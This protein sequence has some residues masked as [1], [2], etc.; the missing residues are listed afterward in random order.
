MVSFPCGVTYGLFEFLTDCEESEVH[1]ACSEDFHISL[2]LSIVGNG[3][4]D[5]RCNHNG[6]SSKYVPQF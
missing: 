5:V 6:V 2:L 1:R 3:F 4:N